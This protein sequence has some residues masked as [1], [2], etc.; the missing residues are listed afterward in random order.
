[1]AKAK[2][3]TLPKDF[4]K[5]LE[6]GDLRKL[7]AVFEGCDVDARGGYGKQTGVAF[8]LCP[9]EP[10][11]WLVGRGAD[12]NAPDER[13]RTPLHARARSRRGGIDVLLERG[14]DVHAAGASI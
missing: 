4:E 14:A 7:Q 13:G 6:A 9:D 5:L 11:R 1:M 2:K 12:V 10:A 8:D 3:K